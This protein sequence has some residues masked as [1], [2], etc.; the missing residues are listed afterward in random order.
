M[1]FEGPFEGLD[2]CDGFVIYFCRFPEFGH[3]ISHLLLP[4]YHLFLEALKVC[5]EVSL[6][7]GHASA[8]PSEPL[9]KCV[10]LPLPV[11]PKII[12]SLDQAA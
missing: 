2:V 3:I 11:S 9:A 6:C 7:R 1:A 12:F 8:D 4:F 5:S 10:Q